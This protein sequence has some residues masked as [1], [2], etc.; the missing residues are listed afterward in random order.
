MTSVPDHR[1][2]AA[3]RDLIR[4]GIA[5]FCLAVGVYYVTLTGFHLFLAPRETW[6]VLAAAT[7]V[8]GAGFLGL[9]AAFRVRPP[10]SRHV[11][12]IAVAIAFVVVGNVTLYQVV[13]GE[14]RNLIN[15]AMINV[16]AGFVVPSY[17]VL[18][19]ILAVD[20]AAFLL[21]V[22]LTGTGDPVFD[23]AFL[24]TTWVLALGLAYT[25]RQT[26]I[27]AEALRLEAE[28]ARDKAERRLE[29]RDR[30]IRAL[31]RSQDGLRKLIETSDQGVLI[32]QDG[33]VRYA[34]R[35]ARALL[36]RSRDEV[37]GAPLAQL[38]HPDD[39]DLADAELLRREADVGVDLRFVD[40]DGDIHLIE[41]TAGRMEYGSGPAA[42]LIFRHDPSTDAP[43][44]DQL[45]RRVLATRPPAAWNEALDGLAYLLTHV[46]LLHAE[47]RRRDAT[48]LEQRVIALGEVAHRVHDTLRGRGETGASGADEPVL[49]DINAVV[50][51]AV[52][53]AWDRV[54]PHARVERHLALG[55][56]QV[57]GRPSR[58]CQAVVHLLHN[59]A[60]AVAQR[61]GQGAISVRTAFED[62]T[63]ALEVRDDGC[64]M[65]DAMRHEVF[66]PFFTAWG[67]A[68]G[69]G[70]GLTEVQEV[71]REH[72]GSID[73]QSRPGRGTSFTLRLPPAQ[74]PAQVAQTPPE[75]ADEVAAHRK[76][77]VVARDPAVADTVAGLLH[78][79]E[80]T[81]C[82][83]GAT[84]LELLTR[85]PWDVVLC[86]LSLRAPRA[87][88]MFRIAVGERPELEGRFAFLAT[89]GIDECHRNFLAEL[90]APALATPFD[91]ARLL[92]MVDQIAGRRA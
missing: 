1:I 81:V 75:P 31:H 46:E 34:N 21:A 70:L 49:V 24:A 4:R 53:R 44:P 39:A 14:P 56:P 55:L 13:S 19:G 65:P 83:S 35:A 42:V 67:D 2:D 50:H 9:G 51:D 71:I 27:M 23:G 6:L 16:V 29:Q 64:G 61:G 26:L 60:R 38:V 90:D 18:L 36:R 80:V 37:V 86:D 11:Y 5:P 58:L 87:P 43:A 30:A 69:M 84:A 22:H 45:A 77:L 66:R 8:T 41:V 32:V 63:V 62:G 40:A 20:A 7:G 72:R 74:P 15:Y 17:P 89:D 68:P 12:A 91:T 59:A 25:R 54:R 28:V 88:E 73:V 82:S 3:A 52:R 85:E 33:V 57:Q 10:A 76:V 47:V 92:A 78:T 79:D 48:D